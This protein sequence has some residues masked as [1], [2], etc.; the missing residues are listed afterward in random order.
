MIQKKNH[1]EAYNFGPSSANNYSVG[2]L[3]DEMEKSWS[4]AKWRDVSEKVM[5]TKRVC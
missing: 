3:I 2:Q 4:K 5:F 1:G